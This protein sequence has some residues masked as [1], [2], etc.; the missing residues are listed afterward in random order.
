MVSKAC[1]AWKEDQESKES[2]ENLVHS[3]LGVIKA[4]RAHEA[5]KVFAY[6]WY[7]CLLFTSG[8]LFCKGA[9]TKTTHFWHSR[10]SSDI[11]PPISHMGLWHRSLDFKLKEGFMYP[12]HGQVGDRH[13]VTLFIWGFPFH[14]NYPL[15]CAFSSVVS[16]LWT[17][18][19]WSTER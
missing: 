14:W 13:L 12:E 1:Q 8:E 19:N 18:D 7:Q 4:H 2:K 11:P 17:Q 16:F 5:L 15:V 3:G 9:Q 10:V 6:G